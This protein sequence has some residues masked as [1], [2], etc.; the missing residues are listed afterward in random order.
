MFL[1]KDLLVVHLC[2]NVAVKEEAD[3]HILHLWKCREDEFA[4][5]MSGC[6]HKTEIS[7]TLLLFAGWTPCTHV[8][9]SVVDAS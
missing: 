3:V 6:Y 8:S 4:A 1:H 2:V 7:Y 5:D 9:V